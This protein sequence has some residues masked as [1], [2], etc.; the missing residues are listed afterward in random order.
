MERAVF[1]LNSK[2]SQE[3]TRSEVA[4]DWAYTIQRSC[5]R[6]WRILVVS[7]SIS[8]VSESDLVLRIISKA[9]LSIS[10]IPMV[11]VLRCTQT[12]PRTI[13]SIKGGNLSPRPNRFSLQSC[14]G[15]Q[16]VPGE[17]RH[18]AQG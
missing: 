2:R 3:S 4:S 1:S 10:S 12:V 9:R 6:P 5:Y 7:F 11:S 16:K 18:R 15:C 8:D 17:A 13:G 14:H